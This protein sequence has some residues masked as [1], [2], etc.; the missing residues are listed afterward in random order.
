MRNIKVF[1]D[2]MRSPI[3]CS[4]YMH[5]RI[6]KSNVIYVEE[7]WIVVRNYEEFVEYVENNYENIG[8]I[9]FDHDLAEEHYHPLMLKDDDGRLEE[10]DQTITYKD[11]YSTFKEK[12]GLECAKWLLEFYTSKKLQLPHIIVHSMNPA[13]TKNINDLFKYGR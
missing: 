6:G 4:A 11:L 9:S 10:D 7:D 1:L 2:D 3:E 13:G 8:L 12:T 5:Y